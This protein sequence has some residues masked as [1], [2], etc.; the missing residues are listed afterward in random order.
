MA[1]P[2][3]IYLVFASADPARVKK[4]FSLAS[5]A[6]CWLYLGRDYLKLRRWENAL[7]KDFRR[8]SFCERLQEKAAALRAPYLDWLTGLGKEYN[9][10][11]WWCSSIAEKNTAAYSL[12]HN[13]CYLAIAR[14]IWR[15]EDRSLLLVA[16]SRA[17]LRAVARQPDMGKSVSW[18][19]TSSSLPDFFFCLLSMVYVWSRFLLSGFAE[20]RDARVTRRGEQRRTGVSERKRI[21]L[22]TCIDDSYF[23]DDGSARDRYFTVLPA[24]LRKKGY[25]VVTMP[26]L[27]NVKRSRRDAFRWFREH[28]GEYLIPEDYYSLK[29]Y[30]WSAF[31]IIRLMN[32][33]SVNRCFQ[34]LQIGQLIEEARRCQARNTVAARFARYYRVVE[35]LS[36]EGYK[37]DVFIDIFENMITEKPQLI[38]FHKYMPRTLTIGFQHYL[39]FYP[40]WLC[41]FT[42]SGERQTAPFPKAIICSSPFTLHLFRQQGFPG[43]MLRAGPSL[44]YLHLLPPRKE[45]RRPKAS[46]L[47]VLTLNT[48]V[49]AET[50]EKLFEAFPTD[51]GFEFLIKVHPM[52]P[53]GEWSMI[54]G[55]RTLPRHMLRVEGPMERWIEQ[56]T[57]AIMMVSTSAIEMLLSGV[58]VILMGRET[59]FDMNPLAWFPD[60]GRPVHT[61]EA[62]RERVFRSGDPQATEAVARWDAENRE[63]L[64]SCLS[65]EAIASFVDD[66]PRAV[67]ET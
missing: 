64:L 31:I 25:D 37:V 59:D 16:E 2:R 60:M 63:R 4:T 20:L 57:C 5:D 13:I 65:D 51:E 9:G 34:D 45:P 19:T 56:A 12:Y 32:M 53:E 35:R 54:L 22:H 11:S 3:T 38:A 61:I 67:H 50:M 24:E 29:D 17:L 18:V 27:C 28:P 39:T 23:G 43:D 42:T 33:P 58:S 1:D 47:V 52:M 10:L 26:W 14:D 36:K 55:E 48:S 46:V 40:L 15:K 62:L 49:V 44:R 8:L 30:L 7:G 66:Y 21:L 41:M 6:P